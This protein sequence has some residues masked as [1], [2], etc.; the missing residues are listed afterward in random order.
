MEWGKKFDSKQLVDTYST[1]IKKRESNLNFYVS[2][3]LFVDY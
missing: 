1:R 2:M 3:L